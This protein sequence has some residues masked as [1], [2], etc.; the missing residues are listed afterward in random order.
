MGKEMRALSVMKGKE[1]QLGVGK[2]AA[3]K[4]KW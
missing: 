1:E 3:S 4:E 2:E